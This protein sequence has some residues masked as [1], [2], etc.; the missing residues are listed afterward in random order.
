MSCCSNQCQYVVGELRESVGN[1]GLTKGASVAGRRKNYRLRKVKSQR[2]DHKQVMSS[3]RAKHVSMPCVGLSYS[4]A[5][6]SQQSPVAWRM[7]SRKPT[8]R[9][10]DRS[11]SAVVDE[12]EEW[13]QVSIQL[14]VIACIVAL[15]L[16]KSLL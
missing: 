13:A 6:Q 8:A 3:S 15:V 10:D 1:A 16:L 2:S 7:D 14:S 9:D 5:L 11:H 12:T 4:S